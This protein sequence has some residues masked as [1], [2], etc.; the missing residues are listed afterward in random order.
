MPPLPDFLVGLGDKSDVK[1]KA[2]RDARWVGDF[3]DDLT[4]AIAL[5]KFDDA[6]MLVQEGQLVYNDIK[7]LLT[8]FTQA[9]TN[10]PA[11]PTWPQN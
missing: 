9:R 6:V 10:P 2:E 3:S 4:V 11:Y 8:Q 7:A 1:E 5:R